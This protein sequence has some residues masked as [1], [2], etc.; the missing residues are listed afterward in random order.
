MIILPDINQLLEYNNP[1]II[2]RYEKD[3]P[4][5]KLSANETLRELVKYFWICQKHK[6]DKESHPQDEGL[7]FVCSMHPEMHEIDDMWHTFL[8]FTQDYAK[9]CKTY[10]L[11]FIHHVPNM[12]EEKPGFDHFELQFTRY[13]SYVYDHLG[14]ETLS[15]WFSEYVKN[16]E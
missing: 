14:K 15:I 7:D 2:A 13:L 1:W 8:L 12:N 10:F 5:N 6:Q 11:S 4:N 16:N 3:H 9:F